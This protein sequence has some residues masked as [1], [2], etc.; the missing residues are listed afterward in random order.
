MTTAAQPL[1]T[2]D[3]FRHVIGHFASGVAIVTTHL[4]GVDHG[5]TASAIASLS[6]E[7][8]MLTV[9][10]HRRSPTQD[11]VERSGRLAVNILREGQGD[12]AHWFAAPRPEKFAAVDV[13]RS[14]NNLPLLS[15][16]LATI[17]CTV[18]D[19]MIGGTHRVFLA[20][21][22]QAEVDGDAVS[23]PL[24][25]FRGSFGHFEPTGRRR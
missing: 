20:R 14:R 10:L 3:E 4:E 16:A 13:A 17:E 6:L 7:P 19:A 2:P 25:Y 12:L 18:E 22:E 8:P 1:V 15:D 5:M 21:V 23:S 11:A 9:S 24:A